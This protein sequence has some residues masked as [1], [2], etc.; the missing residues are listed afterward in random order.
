MRGFA[1]ARGLAALAVCL[2]GLAAT[3]HAAT[4]YRCGPEG[5]TFSQ[6][7]CPAGEG[8]ALDVSDTRDAG[9]RAEAQDAV[10]R[11]AAAA[12][13]M[14]AAR[15]RLEA[16]RVRAP[17]LIPVTRVAESEDRKTSG[18]VAKKK[19]RGRDDGLTV[20]FKGAPADEGD[21][22]KPAAAR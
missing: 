3:G 10:R 20:P 9:Q 4:I 18:K 5:R 1:V 13:S 15:E 14:A 21:R 12:D 8:R 22:K 7:P 11:T 16:A 2:A 19:K 17:G 6:I